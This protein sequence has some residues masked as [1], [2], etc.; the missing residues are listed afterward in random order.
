[1]YAETS[2]FVFRHAPLRVRT[3]FCLPPDRDEFET[4]AFFFKAAQ[5][6]TSSR[7]VLKTK[8]VSSASVDVSE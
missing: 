1:M 2:A 8:K 3:A 5:P 7:I 4:R 6:Q